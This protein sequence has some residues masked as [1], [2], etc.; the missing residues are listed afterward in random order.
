VRVR[1]R[2]ARDLVEG[3]RQGALLV[4]LSAAPVD[5]KANEALVR[6]LGKALGVPPTS[7]AI[8]RGAGARDKVVRIAGLAAAAL[9]ARVDA[10]S[11]NQQA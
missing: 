9:R 2:S 1:P 6:V 7:I 3:E 10:L 4:R 8:L 5:G 11:S